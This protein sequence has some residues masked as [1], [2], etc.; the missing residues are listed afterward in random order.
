MYDGD[1]TE[2]FLKLCTTRLITPVG[3]GGKKVLLADTKANFGSVSR[4]LKRVF[5]LSKI[6]HHNLKHLLHHVNC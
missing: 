1:T 2:G 5:L 3:T 4:D 6:Q